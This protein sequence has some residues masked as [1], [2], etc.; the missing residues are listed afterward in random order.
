[1]APDN[2]PICPSAD[3]YGVG[4]FR[5][6]LLWLLERAWFKVAG[7]GAK[8]WDDGYRDGEKAG[9]V[10]GQREGFGKG[11][12]YCRGQ[13]VRALQLWAEEFPEQAAVG[14]RNFQ[15]AAQ[16][17]AMMTDSG[18]I[19]KFYPT[20]AEARAENARPVAKTGG[21]AECKPSSS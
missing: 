3:Q 16:R 10:Q 6:Q 18:W 8:G 12:Q 1:M 5:R 17:L 11:Y 21:G 15:R 19:P 20:E 13:G 2:S 4:W 7:P 9:R 14:R